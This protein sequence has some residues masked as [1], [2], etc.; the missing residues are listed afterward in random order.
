MHT[1]TGTL[2]DT[3]TEVL[4]NEVKETVELRRGSIELRVFVHLSIPSHIFFA[5]LTSLYLFPSFVFLSNQTLHSHNEQTRTTVSA[6][7]CSCKQMS[8]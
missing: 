8:A 5:L 4:E 3:H 6:V 1:C 2:V 7:R